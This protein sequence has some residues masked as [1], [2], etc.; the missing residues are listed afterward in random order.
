MALSR[1]QIRTLQESSWPE[2]GNRLAQVMDM[3]ELTQAQVAEATGLTQPYVSD[4]CR[5]KHITITVDNAHKFADFFEC[6]IEVLFPAKAQ[7]A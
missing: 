4:V 2:T 1:A 6:S 3:L 7:V 5:G